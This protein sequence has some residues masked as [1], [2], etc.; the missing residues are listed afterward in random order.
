M[1]IREKHY[2]ESRGSTMML[3]NSVYF[4]NNIRWRIRSWITISDANFG[5]ILGTISNTIDSLNYLAHHYMY[6]GP[7]AARFTFNSSE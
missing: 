5:T 4:R 1:K 3:E 7:Y 6:T 2:L